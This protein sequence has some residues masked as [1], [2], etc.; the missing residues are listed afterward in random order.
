M[1]SQPVRTRSSI[2]AIAFAMFSFAVVHTQSPS[3]PTRGKEAD[4]AP[5]LLNTPACQ[6][7]ESG[8]L[9]PEIPRADIHISFNVQVSAS[10]AVDRIDVTDTQPADENVARLSKR[11]GECFRRKARYATS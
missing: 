4:P 9:L 1:A 10:G 6:E 11:F 8:Q 3:G 7:D 5:K 2:L